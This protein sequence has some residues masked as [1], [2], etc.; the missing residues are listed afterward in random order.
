[1]TIVDVL[2]YSFERLGPSAVRVPVADLRAKQQT[3]VV[4]RLRTALAPTTAGY[5]AAPRRAAVRWRYRL[6]GGRQVEAVADARAIVTTDLAAVAAG[7]DPAIVRMV[8]EA[9]TAEAIDEAAGEYADGRIERAQQILRARTT[10]AATAARELGDAELDAKVR[11]YAGAAAAG[12]AAPPPSAAAAKSG[13][14]AR[15]A[16]AYDL[17]R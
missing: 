7:R 2:G 10:E 14:K 9:R 16:E 11:K 13:V 17:A 15:R 4:V 3:K 1:V 12:F 5:R 6:V 8:E